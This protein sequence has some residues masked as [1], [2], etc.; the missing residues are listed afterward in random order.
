MA[1]APPRHGHNV[2]FVSQTG[3]LRKLHAA[4]ATDAYDR[5]FQQ[6]VRVPLLILDLCAARGYVERSCSKASPPGLNPP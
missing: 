6:Y 5:K 3:L 4:R 1:T 2:L